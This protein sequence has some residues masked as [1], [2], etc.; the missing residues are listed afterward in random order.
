MN[1]N[2]SNS[3]VYAALTV[4]KFSHAAAA[5][6]PDPR[7]SLSYLRSMDPAALAALALDANPLD[8]PPMVQALAEALQDCADDTTAED[9]ETELF[10]LRAELKASERARV[11]ALT[12]ADDLVDALDIAIRRVARGRDRIAQLEAELQDLRGGL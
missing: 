9:M 8:L 10:G 11:D 12:R 1:R 5:L 6:R 3:A 4:A 2:P 7:Q